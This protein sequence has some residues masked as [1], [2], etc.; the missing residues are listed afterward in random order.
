[1]LA[2]LDSEALQAAIQRLF[3][4]SKNMDDKSFH[5]FVSSLCKLSAAMV[6]MQSESTE[7]FASQSVDTMDDLNN[8]M[9]SPIT[10]NA[11]R[12]RVS[13]IHLPKTLV[14]RSHCIF[15]TPG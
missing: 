1:M 15:P 8:A 5:D 10:E 9:L 4:A 6:G 14:S 11:H 7:G 13:G 12:R 2:D 3:D